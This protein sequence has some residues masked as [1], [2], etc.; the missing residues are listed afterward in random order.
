MMTILHLMVGL[1]RSGKSRWART[2]EERTGALRFTPDEW[3]LRLFGQDA[4][5]P[6]HDGPHQAIEELIWEV[7][8]AVLRQG[9][10]VI[11]DFG[12]WTRS[13]REAVTARAA[14]L[15][16][17]TRIHYANVLH[18]ELLRRLRM[19]NESPCT[20]AFI[21]SE[22]SLRPWATPFEPPVTE[23]TDC[24]VKGPW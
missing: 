11:L 2:I 13:E 1:P 15:A 19:R 24:E 9:G 4:D 23:D 21:I 14:R 17:S 12:F 3:H 6:D 10:D 18:K 16:A 5:H 8:E 22:A 7:A 20:K